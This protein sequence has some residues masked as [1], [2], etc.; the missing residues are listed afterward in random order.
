MKELKVPIAA[1]IKD[2]QNNFLTSEALTHVTENQKINIPITENFEFSKVIGRI[3]NIDF[4]SGILTAEIELSEDIYLKDK[5]FR[6]QG[7]IRKAT[8]CGENEDAVNVIEDF[9]L[10]AIGMIDKIQDV[11]PLNLELRMKIS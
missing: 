2:K 3:K 7:V 9:E 1:S 5:I 4:L 10:T 11:Y 8:K 6:I